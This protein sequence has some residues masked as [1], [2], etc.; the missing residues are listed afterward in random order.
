MTHNRFCINY[1]L[2]Y[3]D[4]YK[5]GASLT[6]FM[7]FDSAAQSTWRWLPSLLQNLPSDVLDILLE[8]EVRVGRRCDGEGGYSI[9]LKTVHE[10]QGALE[11]L[12]ER[13]R[14]WGLVVIVSTTK[15]LTPLV[16][17]ILD[18]AGFPLLHLSADGSF[19]TMSFDEATRGSILNFIKTAQPN[20]SHELPDENQKNINLKFGPHNVTLPNE[21]CLLSLG[22]KT[23]YRKQLVFHQGALAQFK[24]AIKQSCQRISD[25]RNSSHPA[26]IGLIVLAP[27]ARL[28]DWWDTSEVERFQSRRLLKFSRYISNRCRF[29]FEI[30]RGGTLGYSV[31]EF[32][33]L[34]QAWGIELKTITYAS[35]VKAASYFAPVLRFPPSFGRVN[36]V[37]KHI[38]QCIAGRGPRWREKCTKKYGELQQA[39]TEHYGAYA[40]VFRDK[41][42]QRVKLVD[43]SPVELMHLDGLP[44][45]L[46]SNCSR[47]PVVPGFTAYRHLLDSEGQYIPTSALRR[48][49]VL[50]S[51][52]DDDS[53][54]QT[55][56]KA[57]T[58]Y[59]TGTEFLFVD[60]ESEAELVEAV[61]SWKGAMVVLDCHGFHGIS[62]GE[63][64]GVFLSGKRVQFS[65]LASMGLRMPPITI[66]SAC[67][68][69][70]LGMPV[71]SVA[72]GALALGSTAV[73][74]TTTPVEFVDNAIFTA[75]L[76]YWI[77]V[78]LNEV[79]NGR[80]ARFGWD[81]AY[82][83]TIR[84]H[85]CN[86]LLKVL[87]KR[88]VL[89][90]ESLF[91]V[92]FRAGMA[93]LTAE[94]A[95]FET[96]VNLISERTGLQRDELEEIWKYH[97][98][99]SDALRYVCLGSPERIVIVPD[100]SE[101]VPNRSPGA[102]DQS[103]PNESQSP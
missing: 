82:W 12:L 52:E 20:F 36:G 71:G 66:F 59:E 8:R 78:A 93:I 22:F 94:Q 72:S 35:G 53:G 24:K 37:V 54:K 10:L 91:E 95:W 9:H 1:V 47:I 87:I 32:H 70:P 49:L 31:A 103:V 6:P 16:E 55:L 79:E 29:G 68:T 23:H 40:S 25:L 57:I 101:L 81:Q 90:P 19:G 44:I 48:V 21:L 85:F 102:G 14:G 80:F 30:E 41:K 18:G 67:N 89:G 73:I 7:G 98:W 96:F 65:T 62:R 76:C 11:G 100:G 75:R 64:G 97:W 88:K 27:A 77:H 83:V 50:R 45:A 58:T 17:Q 56:E 84:K 34:V 61:N 92:D 51:F 33:S 4:S 2:V 28:Q 5:E 60:I 86:N 99:T 69:H 46:Q 3:E 42:G 63:T 39:L 43:D 74:A 26:G 15:A 38:R 13:N